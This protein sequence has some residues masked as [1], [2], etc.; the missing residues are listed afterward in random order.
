M[1]SEVQ[2]LILSHVLLFVTWCCFVVL[3]VPTPLLSTEGAG[4]L[5]A[6]ALLQVFLCNVQVRPW[7]EIERGLHAGFSKL[8]PQ[9]SDVER[10]KQQ[11]ADAKDVTARKNQAHK[12]ERVQLQGVVESMSNGVITLDAQGAIQWFNP[13]ALDILG[14]SAEA[15]KGGVLS[16]LLRSNELDDLIHRLTVEEEAFETELQLY[17]GSLQ[18]KTFQ[19]KGSLFKEPVD[20]QVALVVFIDV[21][22]LR[23]LEA[24]RSDFVANVSHELKTPLTSVKGYA[25]TLLNMEDIDGMPRRFVGK[26]AHNADRLHQIIKDLLVLSSLEQDG[27]DRDQMEKMSFKI[28]FDHLFGEL[29]EE[30]RGLVEFKEDHG[31]LFLIQGPLLHL[32]IFNLIDNALK[33]SKTDKVEVTGNVHEGRGFSI[34]VRDEGVG[35]PK[36]HLPYILDRFYRVDKARSREKGGTGLGLSIVKSIVEAHGG[37]VE[38]SSEIGKGTSFK[39]FFPSDLNLT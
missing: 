20:K 24:T 8:E 27:L 10:L 17:K 25:E 22:R 16:S 32:A 4:Y 6:V 2:R 5:V 14:L 37:K 38:V 9:S 19:V 13:C 15:L 33:Y 26:I 7:R 1:K 35:I 29:K 12:K 23:K 28:I 39:C 3:M 21:T 18:E 30:H 31:G 11:W 36:E 34:E